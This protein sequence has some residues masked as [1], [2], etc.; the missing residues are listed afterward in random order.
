MYTQ[1]G[2]SGQSNITGHPHYVGSWYSSQGLEDNQE[3]T[4][5]SEIK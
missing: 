2:S 1:A 5:E 3:L 4:E